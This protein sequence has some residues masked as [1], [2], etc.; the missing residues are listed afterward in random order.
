MRD[1]LVDESLRT[2]FAKG[3]SRPTAPGQLLLLR[4]A[5]GGVS[6]QVVR[7]PERRQPRSGQRDRDARRVDRDPAPPPLLRDDRGGA[8]AARR[9]EDEV[10]RDRWSSG[11]TAGRPWCSS[12]RRRP[13]D[14]RSSAAAGVVPEVGERERREVVDVAHVTERVRRS[15]STRPALRRDAP[16]PPRWSSTRALPGR[17]RLARRTRPGRRV[18][19]P[20]AAGSGCQ[21]VEREQAR[22]L[23]QRPRSARSSAV[24]P[25]ARSVRQ[26]DPAYLPP[27][28]AA[29]APSRRTAAGTSLASR[30]FAYQ[31]M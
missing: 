20:F 22:T 13:S 21:I 11:G 24:M 31:T 2:S 6:E 25:R 5:L 27:P 8:A 28:C 14:R 7:E 4:C 30:S 3:Q 12:G 19:S 16:C 9:I 17:E 23:G 15:R 18:V 26:L 10:T 1:A 29:D